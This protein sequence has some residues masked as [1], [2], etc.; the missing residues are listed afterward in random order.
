MAQWYGCLP[1]ISPPSIPTPW[2]TASRVVYPAAH[3]SLA[4][5]S[6]PPASLTLHCVPPSDG[7]TDEYARQAGRVMDTGSANLIVGS[8]YCLLILN[9]ISMPFVIF[10]TLYL[11]KHIAQTTFPML[12]T[13]VKCDEVAGNVQVTHLF[14][15]ASIMAGAYYLLIGFLKD[16]TAGFIAPMELIMMSYRNYAALG[17]AALLLVLVLCNFIIVRVT[18]QYTVEKSSLELRMEGILAAGRVTIYQGNSARITNHEKQ[19][20]NEQKVV[21]QADLAECGTSVESMAMVPVMLQSKE[22]I[23]VEEFQLRPDKDIEVINEE[24]E[25]GRL[26]AALFIERFYKK[27][28]FLESM[29]KFSTLLTQFLF[30]YTISWCVLTICTNSFLIDSLLMYST[31]AII[32][33]CTTNST[34]T[35][36]CIPGPLPHR[37]VEVLPIATP[38]TRGYLQDMTCSRWSQCI[39]DNEADMPP[40]RCGP[41]KI[42]SSTLSVPGYYAVANPT[43][44]FFIDNPLGTVIPWVALFM[45]VGL[46]YALITGCCCLRIT[47]LPNCV[48]VSLSMISAAVVGI[49]AS[50]FSVA[51]AN[52]ATLYFGGEQVVVPKSRP[53]GV[54][55]CATYGVPDTC[56]LQSLQ[57]TL[58]GS[59]YGYTNVFG[60]GLA[61]NALVLMYEMQQAQAG[62]VI[63]S[64]GKNSWAALSAQLFSSLSLFAYTPV[65]NF[66]SQ[67]VSSAAVQKALSS[68]RTLATMWF[69]TDDMTV[70]IP[71]VA[72]AL[73]RVIG[74][75]SF[76]N[77]DQRV[78][79]AAVSLV[80]SQPG[81]SFPRLLLTMCSIT[82]QISGQII[83]KYT[84]DPDHPTSYRATRAILFFSLILPSLYAI[85]DIYL[86]LCAVNFAYN[87]QAC[88]GVLWLVW[89]LFFV[90]ACLFCDVIPLQLY[91]PYHPVGRIGFYIFAAAP[92]LFASALVVAI[93]RGELLQ[94]MTGVSTVFTDCKYIEASPDDPPLSEYPPVGA[95]CTREEYA[96]TTF[97]MDA[98]QSFITPIDYWAQDSFTQTAFIVCGALLLL[99]MFLVCSRVARF[100]FQ[101]INWYLAAARREATKDGKFT[102]INLIICCCFCSMGSAYDEELTEV[103]EEHGETEGAPKKMARAIPVAE[104]SANN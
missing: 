69:F 68:S 6:L 88:V 95:N 76:L 40:A 21:I 104:A 57:D 101:D 14:V 33:A 87:I 44:L 100:M 11:N 46:V 18:A 36:Y 96:K 79:N 80:W 28:R 52:P 3:A 16:L 47:A 77:F 61:C 38:E 49:S 35:S 32:P 2:R 103:D 20:L 102:L 66:L 73:H 53:T 9:H 65:R 22:I 26:R 15:V 1:C 7:Q 27:K 58:Q 29:A 34:N 41:C 97:G 48:L 19:E 56:I 94:M 70:E 4:T 86:G 17:L 51:F 39:V 10:Y 54:D 30:A 67:F 98:Y 90:D 62:I 91:L 72:G 83:I 74:S 45:G 43:S 55:I 75:D 89:G 71:H 23:T 92:V 59:N 81:R 85:S 99:W 64:D 50:S 31:R 13:P 60:L 84:D 63:D 78:T 5:G 8:V 12:F 25:T 37:V 82:V 93:S 24:L 42:L